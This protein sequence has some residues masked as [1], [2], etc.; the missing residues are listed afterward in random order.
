MT[1]DPGLR[2]PLLHIAFADVVAVVVGGAFFG[3]ALEGVT[4]GALVV[5]RVCSRRSAEEIASSLV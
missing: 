4:S 5:F 3:E 1:T 2:F